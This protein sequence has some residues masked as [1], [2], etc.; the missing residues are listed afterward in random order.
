MA[1]RVEEIF[2]ALLD[3]GINEEELIAQ[4]KEK[5]FEFQGF[6]KK[7][8]ILY[9][10][11]KEKGVNVKTSEDTQILEHITKE[12]IDYNDFAIPISKIA[13]NM[14]NIVISGRITEVHEKREFIKKDGTPGVVS[15][16][17]ICDLS[18]CIKIVLWNEQI[19]I[20]S[21]KFF[22]P[23]EIVQVIGGY[24]KKGYNDTL[25]VHLGRQ[26]K[27]ILAPEGVFLPEVKQEK[28]SDTLEGKAKSTPFKKSIKE[29]YN[30]EGFIRLIRGVVQINKFRE[31][32]QKNGE[33][34][35]LLKLLL[36]DDS[37]SINL[38]IWG[39]KAVEYMKFLVDGV[40]I[41]VTNVVIKQNSY[42]NEKEL[43]S[44]KNTQLDLI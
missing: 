4:V 11:A 15:S 38:N 44:T 19:E 43:S 37:G 9:I 18:E 32:T 12:V 3:A 25:E 1:E 23:Q 30:L 42:S 31:F 22:Q 7:Q 27:V 6:M 41:K 26:G 34:S 29:L 21:N 5:E 33:K 35:F 17:Q 8:A 14:R 24:S 10:I 36:S 28:K 39:L 16:F 40:G 13:E 20:M 2:Q